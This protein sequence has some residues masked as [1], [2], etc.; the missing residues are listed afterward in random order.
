[1]YVPFK[2]ILRHASVNNY[3]VPAPNCPDFN[4]AKAAVVTAQR[5][6]SALIIDIAPRQFKT[7]CN[8]EAMAPMIRELAEEVD[9]PVALNL[10]HG[11]EWEDICRAIRCGFSSVMCDASSLPFEENV[12]RVSQ[13]VAVAHASG[14]SVEAELGHVGQA[15]DGDGRTD[16]MY[17]R[18][19]DAVEFIE[20]TG[21]DSLA[22][23]V[24]T[25]HGK[26]PKGFVPK[27]DFD[28]LAVIKQAVGADYP[29]VLHGGSGAGDANF[30]KAVEN[31]INKV[32]LWTDYS[33]AYVQAIREFIEGKE[34]VD[35]M[36]LSA[37]CTE[38]AGKYLEHYMKLF[39]SAGR[40]V[41]EGEKVAAAD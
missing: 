10:D 14:C 41:F 20:R 13:V 27:L 6:R 3:A 30:K 12:R 18:V 39:G 24:G 5:N 2:E 17:T 34:K 19:E 35:Y 36:E 25:A 26:Y 37:Y 4:T 29:L 15:A 28:R 1:M 32:N 31:G 21:C 11:A 40:Y 23:A 38:E 33:A 22:V 9:V 16:D 7:H 8:P